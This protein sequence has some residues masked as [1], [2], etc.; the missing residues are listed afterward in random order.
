MRIEGSTAL[1][2]GASRGLGI[3][4]VEE[5]CERGARKIYAGA[6][7]PAAL[8]KCVARFGHRI[9]PIR[10]D[11]TQGKDIA[12]TAARCKDLDI[13]ICNAGITC[14]KPFI[15]TEDESA[16]EETMA[17]N[18]RGPMQLTRVLAAVLKD[19]GSAAGI[20]Y[21]LSMAAVIPVHIAPIYSASK[22]A[23]MMMALGAR[24]E[25]K[26][27]GVTVTLSYPGFMDTD[28]GA[29]FDYPKAP[30]RLVAQR[31][32]DAM[33]EGKASVFPDTYARI[34]ERHLL[35]QMP[36]ILHNPDQVLN[37]ILTEYLKDSEAGR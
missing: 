16:F 33:L 22:A 9:V 31:S 17:V 10:L 4:F 15:A 18:Y 14:I 30:P 21:V 25:M 28:M 23:A 36:R 12:E 20:L 32:L 13:F 27:L 7:D 35:H 6:R 5:L 29:M 34:A 37:D 2:T 8:A 11:V 3:A 24:T 26:P 19:R 1:V